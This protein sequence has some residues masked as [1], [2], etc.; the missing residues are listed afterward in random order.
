LPKRPF[1]KK[2][3][4]NH[5]AFG[6]L[7]LFDVA[8]LD[9]LTLLK[10]TLAG[11]YPEAPI[12]EALNFTMTEAEEGRVVFEGTPDESHRNP[13]GTIHAGWTSTVMDSAMAFAVFSAIKSGE[14]FTTVEFKINCVRPLLVGMGKVTC[15]ARLLHRGRTIATSE[16]Y[17]RDQ[18]GKLLAHGTE[19]CAIFLQEKK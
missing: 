12:T 3:K 18:N 6:V 15:E 9:G 2:A 5:M 16:C 1:H 11:T 14:G 8:N 10:G 7:P 4:E 17:V 13:F 19:T